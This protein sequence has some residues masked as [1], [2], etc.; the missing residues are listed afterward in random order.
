MNAPGTAG[1]LAL[2]PRSTKPRHRGI[3]SMIDFGPDQT[4][5]TGGEHGIRDLLSVAADY[6]DY[7][8]IY[9]MNALLIP[10][11]VVKRTTGIYLD[12]GVTPFAGGI[13][14]EYAWVRNEVDQ[15]IRLLRS[16]AIPGIEI[17][18]NYITLNDDERRR[19]I[20]QLQKAGISV[21]YE[22]GR[23]NPEDPLSLDYLRG[24][25]EDVARQGIRHVT[26]E[27]CEIDILAE[28]D[29]AGLKEL[30]AAPWFDHIVIEVDP[31]RFPQ[32][33]VDI[34]NRF[35][36]EV[37]LANVAPGQIL[38]LEGFRRGIGRA[39]NYSLLSGDAS[40]PAGAHRG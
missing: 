20:D 34:I 37:N 16:L 7:A 18:E 39:V 22:F 5:W 4:G 3:T 35:G 36:N 28:G 27:Q 32:Q 40:R 6:I 11:E 31:Y 29:G 38:R 19:S 25:V 1:T 15:L 17:S 21:I 8:K 12:A 9:A 10:A 23:K 13:L 30:A 2:P 24:V 26:V 33:H 14:F